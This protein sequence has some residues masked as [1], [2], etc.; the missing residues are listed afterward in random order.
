MNI[1]KR[2]VIGKTE[3]AF[4]A[5][6]WGIILF[7]LINNYLWLKSCTEIIGVDV[8]NHLF[9]QLKFFNIFK[10]IVDNGAFSIFVRFK[11]LLGLLNTPI[12]AAANIYWPNFVYLISSVFGLC[13]GNSL[14][15]VRFT[16]SIFL[17]VLM[18]STYF[19][20]KDTVN[21]QAG[22]LA[23]FLVSI[24]PLVFESSRQYSLD[25][26]LAA[27]VTLSI[28][29]LMRTNYFTNS[30]Y[31]ILLGVSAGTAML[32]KG[33]FILF[34][35]W[36]FLLILSRYISK[37]NK[38][39][40]KV[41]FNLSLFMFIAL[42]VA[43]LWWG[44]K[45]ETA[46]KEFNLHVASRQKFLENYA[47]YAIYSP[48]FYFFHLKSLF[49]NSISIPLAIPFWVSFF[50]ILKLKIKYK[51][52]LLAWIVIPFILFSCCF[53]IKHDRFLMPILPPIAIFSSCVIWQ[54]NNK[55]LRG[56]LLALLVITAMVIYFVFSY[57]YLYCPQKNCIRAGKRIIF[58]GVSSSSYGSSLTYDS[59][60]I[61][62]TK[63]AVDLITE[64]YG[65]RQ[66]YKLGTILSSGHLGSN[67]VFYWLY[68]WNN[69]LYVADW[70]ES[71]NSFYKE[72]LCFDYLI[73]VSYEEDGFVWPEREKFLAMLEKRRVINLNLI[74][75]FEGWND[76]FNRLCSL[77]K[78]FVLLD[79]LKFSNGLC[80]YIYKRKHNS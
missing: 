20:A 49:L 55:K 78:E 62:L 36:P 46:F 35:I 44:N 53:V 65:N 54:I 7:Q 41:L 6:F 51:L 24:Y 21:K 76:N 59:E 57:F 28:F 63:K 80:W 25:L 27:L 52:I 11:D 73:F 30:F 48:E 15:T 68:Y 43:S 71:Y 3:L 74:K 22:L 13:A 2:F 14:F 29:F 38:L 77:G 79:T 50:C 32:I 18:V 9:Y 69:E 56:A 58:T 66:N 70:L 23:M 31:S 12:S 37:N 4:L 42:L 75:T 60:K 19:I 10:H 5:L 61:A 40:L 1:K 72:L 45:M 34:F 39:S 26:P 17:L 64:D 16:V 47:V 67:E 8:A 33:Q